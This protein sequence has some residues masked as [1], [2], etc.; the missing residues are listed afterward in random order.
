MQPT[1]YNGDFAIILRYFPINLIQNGQ[2]IVVKAWESSQNQ[3]Y[4]IKRVVG[5]PSDKLLIYQTEFRYIKNKLRPEIYEY[6][7]RK[8]DLNQ[9]VLYFDKIETSE[10]EKSNKE[11]LQKK[12]LISVPKNHFFLVGDWLF[13]S[14]DSLR[15]GPV[16]FRNFI[17][18]VIFKF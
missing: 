11:Y 18:L 3:K 10:K 16:H 15:S 7:Y 14:F 17:G 8:I 5:I 6:F 13:G 12:R 9:I 4:I 2:I 1:L